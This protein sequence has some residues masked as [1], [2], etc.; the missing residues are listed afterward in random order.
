MKCIFAST[1]RMPKLSFEP[2]FWGVINFRAGNPPFVSCLGTT[3]QPK[4]TV[5]NPPTK[6]SFYRLFAHRSFEFVCIVSF[7][8]RVFQFFLAFC[9]WTLARECTSKKFLK[10][11]SSHQ[12]Q[13][14]S[15]ASVLP[16]R[17][18]RACGRTLAWACLLCRYAV[19]PDLCTWDEN[20]R[21]VLGDD[22]KALHAPGPR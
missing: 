16:P 3:L 17:L 13:A 4:R 15:T 2:A 19:L 7:V 18:E 21:I 8:K 11:S 20:K 10:C 1:E 5:R 9:R 12:T 6:T 14:D 22:G